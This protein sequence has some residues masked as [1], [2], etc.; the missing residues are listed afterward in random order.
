MIP[1]VVRRDGDLV[2]NPIAHGG[3][4]PTLG[5]QVVGG[6]LARAV[7][8][9]VGDDGL[10]PARLT[11]EILRRVACAPLRVDA[12]VV[13]SGS[14]MRAIDA[15]MTQGGELVARASALYLR[16]GTQPDG[17][18]FTTE[19]HLPPVPEEPAR[20]DDSVPM[21]IR[22]YGTED[23]TV[24]PWQHAGPRYAWLREIRDLVEGEE[25]T[26][27]VRAAMAVDVTASLT[28]FSTKG[29]GF[30]NADYTLTLSRLPVGPYIG[31]AALTHYSDAG[32]ATGSASLFDTLG[33]IG[34]GVST[35]IANLNFDADRKYDG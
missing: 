34:S 6:L 18:F 29:L 13:R 17:D 16:R 30:I 25:L 7:E 11:V 5:G 10:Q 23:G 2:P 9:H 22:A 32:V 26:P 21:F 33:P 19:V 31:L 28:N 1:F 4:G 8:Q 24:I 20:L 12:S 35:A 27:F 14:R 3:W 15:E